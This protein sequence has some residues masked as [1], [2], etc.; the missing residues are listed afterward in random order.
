MGLKQGG[1]SSSPD[2]TVG[3]Y[4]ASMNAYGWSPANEF[5]TGLQNN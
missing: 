1:G 5:G 4:T 2:R 3:A